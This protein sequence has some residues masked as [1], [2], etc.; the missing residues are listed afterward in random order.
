M[1]KFCEVK[2]CDLLNLE[3]YGFKLSLSLERCTNSRVQMTC[4][5]MF[6]QLL[7][8]HLYAQA[9]TADFNNFHCY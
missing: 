4:T 6:R 9:V 8:Y 2:K 1:I 5:L 7:I 3:R